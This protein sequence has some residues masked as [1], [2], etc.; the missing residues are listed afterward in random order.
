MDP[1]SSPH[2]SPTGDPKPLPLLKG[3]LS[4][5]LVAETPPE[6]EGGGGKGAV[7]LTRCR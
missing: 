1:T 2:P 3:D 6:K 5:G 4:E 7:A